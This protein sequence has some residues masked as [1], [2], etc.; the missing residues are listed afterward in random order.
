MLGL[1]ST[2]HTQIPNTYTPDMA[3]PHQ[4]IFYFYFFRFLSFESRDGGKVGLGERTG[5]HF[6]LVERDGRR[7]ELGRD[8][9][10]REGRERERGCRE[11]RLEREC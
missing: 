3:L 4:I 10:R 11:R 9:H 6:G 5:E 7:L 8:G 1:H 2:P